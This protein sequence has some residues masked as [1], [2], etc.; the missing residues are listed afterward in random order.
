MCALLHE[1]FYGIECS[2]MEEART[3]YYTKKGNRRHYVPAYS[4]DIGAAMRL[5]DGLMFFRL[6]FRRETPSLWQ[7]MIAMRGDPCVGYAPTAP[8]A[9]C[10]AALAYVKAHGVPG[11]GA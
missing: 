11:V 2:W 7:A 10:R 1:T 5:V 8:L 9:I 4:T 6:D 3:W